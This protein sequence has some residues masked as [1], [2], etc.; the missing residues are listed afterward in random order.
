MHPILFQI[1][2]FPVYTYGL[3]MAMGFLIG[4]GWI[5]WEAKRLGENLDHYYNI[6]LIALVGGI[7]G[8]RII[9]V[10]VTW[11]AYEGKLWSII[12]LRSGGLVWYGGLITVIVLI[13]GY[14]RWKSL[15]FYKVTDIIAAPVAAGL[16]VGRLGCLMSGCC[17]GKVCDLPWAI[18]YPDN[19]MLSPD[20]IGVRVHPSPVY[21]MIACMVIAGILAYLQRR[22]TR[23]GQVIWTF[24]LLYG[25]VRFILELWRGDAVRGFIGAL[26]VSQAVSIP[27]VILAATILLRMRREEKHT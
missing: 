26:S 6:C 11:E 4:F 19:P 17:Y 2:D 3:T 20:I 16:A 13:L 15:S 18:R 8:A 21:E 10:I 12:N 7:V 23:D 25:A 1:G 14:T 5:F 24:L 22:K 27:V 9:H